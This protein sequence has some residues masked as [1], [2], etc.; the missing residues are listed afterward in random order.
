MKAGQKSHNQSN[1]IKIGSSALASGGQNPLLLHPPRPPLAFRVGIVGHRPDRLE[2][3]D[4]HLLGNLVGDILSTIRENVE[5][6]GLINKNIYSDSHPAL[7]AI[8]PLAE[9]TDRIFAEQAINQGY[10]LSCPMPFAQ[11]EYEKD[12]FP[13]FSHEVNSFQRFRD[14][15]DKAEETTRLVRFEMD[16]SRT[17]DGDAFRN[18]GQIVLNQSDLL[19][20]VWDGIYYDKHG[21]TEETLSSARVQQIPVIWIDAY[22]PHQW[23]IA[24]PGEALPEKINNGRHVPRSENDMDDIG[25]L[26]M[27]ILAVPSQSIDHLSENGQSKRLFEFYRERQPHWNIALLWKFFR[28]LTGATKISFQ[29]PKLQPFDN[30]G[31]VKNK[32]YFSAVSRLADWLKPYYDWPD[33][34]AENY[35]DRYRSGFILTYLLA[36]FAVGTALFPLMSGWLTSER[37][38][39]LTVC[40][41]IESFAILT[42]LGIVFFT[43]KNRWHVRWLD[44]RMTAESIRQLKLFLPL[45]GG[46]PFPKMSAHLTQ[47]GNPSATWMT[48]Y[49]Q[50]IE[51]AAGLPAVRVDN[52]HLKECLAQYAELLAEQQN[53]H[54][55][56]ADLNSKIEKRL[57]R[58]GELTMWLTLLA[59]LVH[60]LPVLVPEF[61]LSQVTGNGLIFLCGFL[62]ALGAS[63][64]G[65]NHQGE[66]RRIARSSTAMLEQFSRLAD[67]TRRLLNDL[68][69]GESHQSESIFSQVTTLARAIANL[70]INEVSDWK[71]VFQD[72]PPTLPA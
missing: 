60:L 22:S 9:G 30:P 46:K 35:A 18:N 19:L 51:R 49:V 64:A 36:S 45:G 70:M 23:Q 57:H 6:T 29:S 33:K 25:K 26:V 32:M 50:A 67:D 20:I 21:G 12:F 2:F 61:R 47:Y 58:T 52:N 28:N 4:L 55:I 41:I 31:R 72:R 1:N 14:I 69:V 63:M 16:G 34:L 38:T 56:N 44:Y 59:C 37:H 48:W 71:V 40:I 39:G 43:R 10:E 65:I 3:A 7:R 5:K 62:P 13:E 8:S 42:I 54:K 24:L 15:L 27:Q 53:Y 11:E 66:F 17:N 68:S